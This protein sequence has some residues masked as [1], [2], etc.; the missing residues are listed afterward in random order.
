MQ[1]KISQHEERKQAFH[2]ALEVLKTLKDEIPRACRENHCDNSHVNTHKPTAISLVS[3]TPSVTR[4]P[5]PS[6]VKLRDQ[7]STFTVNDDSAL[8]T[9]RSTLHTIPYSKSPVSHIIDT[10]PIYPD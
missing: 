8:S 9:E 4:T 1:H 10:R 6:Q 5:V 2:F 3:E 7:G